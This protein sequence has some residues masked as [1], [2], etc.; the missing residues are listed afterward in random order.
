MKG[1][2]QTR[3]GEPA[4]ALMLRDLDRPEVSDDH[5]LI[6]VHAASIHIGDVYGIRGLPKSMRPIFRAMRGP[7]GVV[8]SDV[9]G[10]V[11][12]V[13]GNVTA[14]EP[15]DE[16]FGTAKGGFAEF[17]SAKPEQGRAC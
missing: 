14:F 8:G 2:V 5:V 6:R 10:T 3:F 17:A 4:D 11:E 7:G 13:G 12:A 1:I 15:G 9:A 16:V